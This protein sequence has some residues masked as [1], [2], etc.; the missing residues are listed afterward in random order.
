MSSV[1]H[2][3]SIHAFHFIACFVSVLDDEDFQGEPEEEVD[4][5]SEDFSP[6]DNLP[7]LERLD[8]YFQSEELGER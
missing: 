1:S 7:P 2:K 5:L 3:I 6:D 4:P 8:K